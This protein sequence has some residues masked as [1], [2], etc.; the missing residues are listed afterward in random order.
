MRIFLIRHA[1]TKHSK[2]RFISDDALDLGIED[3]YEVNLNETVRCFR[4]SKITINHVYSSPYKRSIE[5][6]RA[7]FPKTQLEVVS[8][9]KELDKGFD[10]FLLQNKDKCNMTVDDWESIYNNGS[11][12]EKSAYLYPSGISIQNYITE[13]VDA[14]LN[15]VKNNQDNIA[16]VCHNGTIK[17]ILTEVLGGD[18]SLYFRI[19]TENSK[20]SEIEY[21]N[22]FFKLISLNC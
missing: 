5:T 19:K 16:I 1:K 17:A 2:T 21:E 22:S 6:A 20:I 12:K 10:K 3:L 14:F 4:S 13:V 7:I 9:F 15:I 11:F 8:C 18:I